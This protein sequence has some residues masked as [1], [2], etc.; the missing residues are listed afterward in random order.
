MLPSGDGG[1]GGDGDDDDEEL[2]EEDSDEQRA[3]HAE[4]A[5][6]AE[7][8]EAQRASA[9]AA[10]GDDDSD[11]DYAGPQPL[12]EQMVELKNQSLNYGGATIPVTKTVFGIER[13][14]A[15]S[16]LPVTRKG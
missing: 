13:S 15:T 5:E 12:P 11:D 9:A 2:V 10:A 3:A 7:H 6:L 8:F 16:A 14:A 1:G 4:G